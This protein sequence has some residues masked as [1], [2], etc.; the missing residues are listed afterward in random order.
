[1][2]LERIV[3]LRHDEPPSCSKLTTQLLLVLVDREFSILLILCGLN[4]PEYIFL[5]EAVDMSAGGYKLR[6]L[7]KARKK[8]MEEI[9]GDAGISYKALAEIETG[10]TQRPTKET[11]DKILDALDRVSPISTEERLGIYDAFDYKAPFPLPSEEEVAWARKKWQEDYQNVPYP[12]YFV[13]FA[14][15]LLDWNRYIPRFLGMKYNDPA[16]SRFR[17][18]TIFDLA[19]NTVYKAASMI[20]NADE[21]LPQMIYVIRREFQPFLSEAWCIE[22]VEKA[23]QEYP[24][25]KQ[26]WEAVPQEGL[27]ALGLRTMGPLHLRVANGKLLKFQLIGTDFAFDPRFRAVQYIPLDETT[28]RQ[29]LEWMEEEKQS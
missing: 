15:R 6:A 14:Q 19:F 17:N 3:I 22:C 29:C 24:K 4:N 21:F 11:L 26:L 12:A 10:V 23:Q 8:S 27:Q 7:R 13:D 25:F 16:L 2:D 9:A 1:M 20:E 5:M 18:I 28:M